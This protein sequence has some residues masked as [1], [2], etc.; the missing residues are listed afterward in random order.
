MPTNIEM[1]I[2]GQDGQYQT[3]YPN[4]SANSVVDFSGN[5]PLLSDNTKI[6]YGLDSSSVPDDIFSLI[7]VAY[8]KVM[9][10][11]NVYVWRSWTESWEAVASNTDLQLYNSFVTNPNTPISS[12]YVSNEITVSDSGTV[13]MTNY[14]Q[15]SPSWYQLEQFYNYT[16]AGNSP[17]EFG[18]NIVVTKSQSGSQYNFN[19]TTKKVVSQKVKNYLPNV[20]SSDYNTYPQN[21]EVDGI[22]YLFIGYTGGFSSIEKGQYIGTGQPINLVFNQNPQ[23]IIITDFTNLSQGY[24]TLLLN[25]TESSL[26]FW[27]RNNDDAYVYGDVINCTFN[28]N[29]ITLD[30]NAGTGKKGKTYKYY[31]I[32]Q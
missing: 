23:I 29:S 30:S 20:T 14:T 6:D 9:N 24:V 22:Y 5:N 15:I 27:K 1:N 10:P 16:Y 18:T 2:L 31:A 25:S 32:V 26:Q 13:S 4:V 12:R 11:T 7:S 28:Q 8:D 17:T 19:V 21:G 3:L